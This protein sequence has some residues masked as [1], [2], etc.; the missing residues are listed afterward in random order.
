MR[1]IRATDIAAGLLA[2][3]ISG[4]AVAH[5]ASDAYLTLQTQ[6]RAASQG[7]A[8][9]GQWDIALRD[10]HFVLRLDDD[11]DGD[12]A[13]G[14]VRQHQPEIARYAY[15]N[16]QA[17]GDGKPCAI[18]PTRQAITDH[19]DGAYVALFF[20][21]VCPG[22]PRRLTLDYRLF[23]DIDPS[24]RGILVLRSGSATSTALVSPENAKIEWS[25]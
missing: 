12:I 24:H 7:A 22:A 19:A 11:G 18:T 10:L 1:T 2:V 9:H 8:I 4:V 5:S 6:A 13:W 20:D 23:F 25:P 14:E 3:C 16:L 21:V 17:R 15:R